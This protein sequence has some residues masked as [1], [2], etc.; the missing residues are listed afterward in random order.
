[1]QPDFLTVIVLQDLY[2]SAAALIHML[3]RRLCSSKI[4]KIC[5]RTI[6]CGRREAFAALPLAHLPKL[7]QLDFGTVDPDPD[8]ERDFRSSSLERSLFGRC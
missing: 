4:H 3:G 5:I 2:Y 1:M 6:S 7:E 8:M